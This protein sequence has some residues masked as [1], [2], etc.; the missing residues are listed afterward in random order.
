MSNTFDLSPLLLKKGSFTLVNGHKRFE[1][2]R[3]VE[4]FTK[5]EVRYEI[6]CYLG[7]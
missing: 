6:Q 7:S 5:V 1:K 3:I 4:K 2:V